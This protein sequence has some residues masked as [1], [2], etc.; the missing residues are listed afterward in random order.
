MKRP[1]G[2]GCSPSAGFAGQRS[3]ARGRGDGD[4]AAAGPADIELKRA[5]NWGAGD[6][7]HAG[8]ES[9]LPVGTA[10]TKSKHHPL[11][12]NGDLLT[13]GL[14]AH[15]PVSADY[16]KTLKSI[17]ARRLPGTPMAFRQR[18]DITTAT[19]LTNIGFRRS[20]TIGGRGR[21]HHQQPGSAERTK[22]IR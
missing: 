3:L 17:R 15:H 7:G 20:G 1:P 5:V 2:A 22:I 6:A 9:S 18:D 12:E 11:K 10:S 16:D 4:G 8:L 19:K 21:R 13:F 14:R